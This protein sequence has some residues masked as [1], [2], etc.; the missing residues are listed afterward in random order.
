LRVDRTAVRLRALRRRRR[1]CLAVAA[2]ILV[3][4]LIWRMAPLGLSPFLFKY[5]GSALWAAM[6][7]WIAAAALPDRPGLRVA[8]YAGLTAS[9]VEATRLFHTPQ[10]DAFRLTLAGRLLL[11]RFF[12]LRDIVVYWVAWYH[13]PR[14]NH[15]KAAELRGQE[16]S[17]RRCDPLAGLKVAPRPLS[18]RLN[19]ELV[20]RNRPDSTRR[21]YSHLPASTAPTAAAAR[22]SAR[23]R[24]SRS[25]WRPHPRPP[26]FHPA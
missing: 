11:G 26:G 7:Y 9:L 3:A 4:G 13:P 1:R 22:H 20:K 14:R 19:P 10:L 16:R 24:S 8:M 6:V 23:T 21:S 15:A 25:A 18:H 5:G 2:S 12:S 17:A